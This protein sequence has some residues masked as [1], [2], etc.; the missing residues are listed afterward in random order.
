MGWMLI[1]GM[2]FSMLLSIL[3]MGW[4]QIN[5]T[6][7][8]T[9]STKVGRMLLLRKVTASLTAGLGFFILIAFVTLSFYFVRNDY[10]G[11]WADNVSSGYNYITDLVAGNRPFTTWHSFTVLG[12]LLASLGISAGLVACSS[13]MGAAAGVFAK[14]SYIGFLGVMLVN[15]TCIVI[16]IV[17]TPA[18]FVKYLFILT[19]VWLWLKSPHWFTDG[20]IDVLFKN[21][22]TL[23]LC[24]SL[25]M[26]LCVLTAV[27]V[28]FGKRDLV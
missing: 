4:E 2:I 5:H 9:Y 20:T 24:L 12:Y 26:T 18:V 25:G 6:E 11:V 23:G 14:N 7:L 15:A 19:P 21:F 10:S 28:R 3:S 17:V 22:E 1:E 16:P 13:L 27:V 8:L